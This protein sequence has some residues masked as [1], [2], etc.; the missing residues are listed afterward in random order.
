MGGVD[1][2]WILRHHTSSSVQS[3][4]FSHRFLA[5][6]DIS[7]TVSLVDLTTL[8]PAFQWSAHTDSILTILIIGPKEILTHARDNTLKHWRLSHA[9]P[10]VG[11]SSIGGKLGATPELVRTIGVNALNFSK[12]SYDKGKVAVPNALD[13]AYIDV[14][15]LKTGARIHEAIGRPDIKPSVGTRLP[16]VMSL[17]L[18]GDNIVAGYEDGIVKS[19]SISSNADVSTNLR[20]QSRCHSESVMSV[21]LCQEDNFGISVG[22]DDR[23]AKFELDTGKRELVQT[24]FPGKASVVIAPDAKTFA[25]GAWDR[26]MQELGQLNYHRDTVECLIFA[27]VKTG[28]LEEDE[29]SDEDEEV[30]GKDAKTQLILA[31]GCRDG[32]ISL[33]KYS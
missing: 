12:C 2:Y 32:K 28:E 19:W 26:S 18:L 20:W 27:S 17:H 29:D 3:L 5:T 30:E 23:I 31:A 9:P 14:L 25:V 13:A 10:S 11:S 24:K 7:G 8:R 33:W 1:P 15:E 4:D 6:G 16:I 22:A 21:N